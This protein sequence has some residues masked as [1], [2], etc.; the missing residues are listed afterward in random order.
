MEPRGWLLMVYKIPPE[1]SRYRVA[2]WRRLKGA[3]AVYLQNSVAV[4]PDSPAHRELL[5][6]VAR[7]IDEAGG[8]NVILLARA[9]GT[10]EEQKVIT[11]FNAERDVEYAELLEQCAAFLEEIR[12]ETERSNFTFAELEEN[13]EGLKR[14]ESWLARISQR[15]M[16]GA[17]R[18]EQAQARVQECREA[19]ERFAARIFAASEGTQP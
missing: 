11:R 7:E 12:Y 10:E 13:E 2:V 15:D 8:E 6:G 19:F 1:P 9:P 18:A 4:L 16:F 17:A 5:A 3:G 14:L